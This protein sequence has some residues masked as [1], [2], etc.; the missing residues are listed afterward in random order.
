MHKLLLMLYLRMLGKGISFHDVGVS[1]R[2]IL[3]DTEEG[4]VQPESV[5]H[6]EEK[7]N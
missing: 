1:S 7:Y 3:N 2:D 6:E 5:K 4:I